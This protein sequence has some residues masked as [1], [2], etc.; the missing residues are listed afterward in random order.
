MVDSYPYESPNNLKS[1]QIYFHRGWIGGHVFGWTIFPNQVFWRPYRCMTTC[2]WR[3]YFFYLDRRWK[4]WE[5]D[6]REDLCLK[7]ELD[8]P[9]SK[10][11]LFLQRSAIVLLFKVS[12]EKVALSLWRKTFWA[13]NLVTLSFHFL[14]STNLVAPVITPRESAHQLWRNYNPLQPHG[15][16]LLFGIWHSVFGICH[17]VS[18]DWSYSLVFGT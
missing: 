16:D 11:S 5:A 9:F 17:M 8:L 15:W 3:G 1:V 13:R 4:S 18:A 2:H 6:W 14:P 10:M 12:P 7:R